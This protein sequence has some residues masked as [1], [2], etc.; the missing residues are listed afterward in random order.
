MTTL[1]TWIKAASFW[2]PA[3]ASAFGGAIAAG[4]FDMKTV[5]IG[6]C[7]AIVPA[8]AAFRAYYSISN[9]QELARG[10]V[11]NRK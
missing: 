9:A 6:L 7:A 11:S 3:G 5:L 8:F 1:P 10:P 4:G 2:I